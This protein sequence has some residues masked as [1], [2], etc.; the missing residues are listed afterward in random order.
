MSLLIF[1][2]LLS[3]PASES[4]PPTMIEGPIKMKSSEIRKYNEGLASD[5]PNYIRCIEESVTGSLARRVKTCRTNEEWA[6]VNAQGN[7]EARSLVEPTQRGFTNG[8][9]PGG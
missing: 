8:L 6:R 2:L 1:A 9:P 5:H 4:P 3:P 7:D